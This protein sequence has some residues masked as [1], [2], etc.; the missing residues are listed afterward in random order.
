[1]LRA[2]NVCCMYPVVVVARPCTLTRVTIDTFACAGSSVT[3]AL[4]PSETWHRA[5]GALSTKAG[6]IDGLSGQV[7]QRDTMKQVKC[8]EVGVTMDGAW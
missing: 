7:L 8:T 4:F 5:V 6:K 3:S 1:M 2:R